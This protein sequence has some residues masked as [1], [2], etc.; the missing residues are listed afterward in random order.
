MPV[1]KIEVTF[2]HSDEDNKGT[3]RTQGNSLTVGDDREHVRRFKRGR[4]RE[5]LLSSEDGHHMRTI[6]LGNKRRKKSLIS[7]LEVTKLKNFKN[8]VESRILLKSDRNLDFAMD[9]YGG[10]DVGHAS[11]E[12]DENFKPNSNVIKN[13]SSF[14]NSKN[15][16]SSSCFFDGETVS[17]FYVFL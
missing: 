16:H 15:R 11:Y 6:S 12:N 7:G 5:E 2:Y 14:S 10:G 17:A 9:A 13:G 8:F 1:P 4:H 3:A